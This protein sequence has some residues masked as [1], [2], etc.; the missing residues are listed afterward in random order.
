MGYFFF[1]R[2][3]GVRRAAARFPA[4]AFRGRAFGRATFFRDAAFFPGAAFFGAAFLRAAAFR[5]GFGRG[6][7]ALRGSPTTAVFTQVMGGSP[8]AS[9]VH[10]APPSG[11]P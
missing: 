2:A 11:E 4:A 3:A 9:S 5:R 10:D 6:T 7:R 1:V 8:S